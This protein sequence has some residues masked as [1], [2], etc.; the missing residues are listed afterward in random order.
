MSITN[1]WRVTALDDDECE[2]SE[3]ATLE[4]SV[5]LVAYVHGQIKKYASIASFCE[6]AFHACQVA[7]PT[8]RG[9]GCKARRTSGDEERRV[10]LPRAGPT[11][12][13]LYFSSA[14]TVCEACVPWDGAC[15]QVR[16]IY[17]HVEPSLVCSGVEGGCRITSTIINSS[18]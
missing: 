16:R 15:V 13:G 12:P 7:C 5:L 1:K 3:E 14:R 17:V 9:Y 18:S 11:L 10:N 2:V 6:F 8:A 4:T